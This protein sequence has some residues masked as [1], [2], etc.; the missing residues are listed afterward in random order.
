M[1]SQKLAGKR[2]FGLR[3]RKARRA[4]TAP[5]AAWSRPQAARMNADGVAVRDAHGQSRKRSQLASRAERARPAK[6]VRQMR[7]A[8]AKANG[9]IGCND[10]PLLPASPT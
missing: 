6:A 1:R 7:E 9:W 4:R 3:K 8:T 5:I 10:R 2:P